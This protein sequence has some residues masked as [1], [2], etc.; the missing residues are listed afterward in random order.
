L[1]PFRGTECRLGLDS[2]RHIGH[3]G[4]AAAHKHIRRKDMIDG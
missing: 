4:T 1:D 3:M 2:Q